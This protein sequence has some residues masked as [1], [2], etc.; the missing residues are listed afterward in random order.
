MHYIKEE[1]AI[2]TLSEKARNV[3][4]ILEKEQTTTSQNSYQLKLQPS[5]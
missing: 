2:G 4:T 5:N 1:I 3:I